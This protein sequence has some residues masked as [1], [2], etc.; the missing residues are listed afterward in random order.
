MLLQTFHIGKKVSIDQDHKLGPVNKGSKFNHP[1]TGPI[2]HAQNI[3]II[4]LKIQLYY[5]QYIQRVIT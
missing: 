2:I 3:H 1:I 4:L 5:L